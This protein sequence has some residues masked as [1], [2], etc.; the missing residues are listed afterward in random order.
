MSSQ[1]S[2][3]FAFQG[4]G[5]LFFGCQSSAGLD[6]EAN[7]NIF[8]G[9]QRIVSI[10]ECVFEKNT[11][12]QEGGGLFINSS[13]RVIINSIFKNNSASAG[14][15][16]WV[17]GNAKL[18]VT[19]SIFYGNSAETLGG[20]VYI[21][22]NNS[23][24]CVSSQFS[25]NFAFQGG[26]CLFV[27]SQSNATLS[28]L[29]INQNYEEAICCSR[30]TFTNI[31]NCTFNK[32]TVAISAYRTMKLVVENSE[33]LH[34]EA[35]EGSA[36]M[37]TSVNIF[38]ISHVRFIQNIAK[39]R[40]G[41]ITS[42]HVNHMYI[43][44]S[45]FRN[46]KAFYDGG[47][48]E[49]SYDNV[50][51][52]N[53]HFETNSAEKG[54]GGVLFLSFGSVLSM[55]NCSVKHSYAANGGAIQG[56]ECYIDLR[57]CIFENN[58]AYINGG[59]V[60]IRGYSLRSY[61]VT[62]LNNSVAMSNEG[63]GGAIYAEQCNIYVLNSFFSGNCVPNAWS[64]AISAS[65]KTDLLHIINTTFSYNDAYD[66]AVM[67][68]DGVG[69]IM[70]KDSIFVDNVSKHGPIIYA[71]NST[72]IAMNCI[73]HNNSVGTFT[74]AGCLLLHNGDSSFEN[75]SFKNNYGELDNG[76]AIRVE[77][78]ELRIS[79]SVFENNEVEGGR[80]KDIFL[81]N[82]ILTYLSSFKHSQTYNST[83]ENFKQKVFKD[84]IFGSDNPDDVTITESQYA[85]GKNLQ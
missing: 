53:S 66:Y 8:C 11:A 79:T 42:N 27:G 6:N 77:Q 32:N 50:S 40:G 52:K 58:T 57:Y 54:S 73:F 85:S 61:E 10:K 65:A 49:S 36:I 37:I 84:N 41:V 48:L 13:N 34:N 56:N 72:F 63:N 7:Y 80:G 83:E 4:G 69:Q 17:S 5:G 31:Y 46:N 21:S 22:R 20:A 60:S 33:F 26:S 28:N 45:I 38:V 35:L 29:T 76:G 67:K 16:V 12:L 71:F 9:V 74:A 30:S 14:G 3:H 44:D 2:K 25:K 78:Q 64:G 75:C 59:A 24:I 62:Y 55:L 51:F 70:L 19:N 82:N 39:A 15:G 81:D 23:I 47:V 1:F 43:H 68:T 18:N